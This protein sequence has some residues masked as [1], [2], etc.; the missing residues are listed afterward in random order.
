MTLGATGMD[1]KQSGTKEVQSDRGSN[2]I[3]GPF[4]AIFLKKREREMQK[5]ECAINKR[6]RVQSQTKG[7]MK[8]KLNTVTGWE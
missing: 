1:F 4:Q 3:S 7:S 5:T 2:D 8:R 6:L